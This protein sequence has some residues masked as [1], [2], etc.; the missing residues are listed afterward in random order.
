MDGSKIQ[1]FK[2]L[3]GASDEESK[4]YLESS[5]WDLQVDY[6]CPN[7]QHSTM[8]SKVKNELHKTLTDIHRLPTTIIQVEEDMRNLLWDQPSQ[9]PMQLK[10]CKQSHK[11]LGSTFVDQ[12]SK[13]DIILLLS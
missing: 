7:H 10:M 9:Q 8:L 4:F 13:H 5:N 1:Q 12:T 2:E 11:Q 3:T 6:K